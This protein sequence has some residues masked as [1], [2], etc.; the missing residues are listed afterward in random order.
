MHAS[1]FLPL[2]AALLPAAAFAR[3]PASVTT[4]SFTTSSVATIPC[5]TTSM[6]AACTPIE[7]TFVYPVVVTSSDYPL[8]SGYAA[9]SGYPYSGYGHDGKGNGGY[10]Y[11][12]GPSK[13]GPYYPMSNSTLPCG[14]GTAPAGTAVGTGVGTVG[15][16]GTFVTSTATAGGSE[17][18]GGES[19]DGTV[20]GT[21]AKHV[22][23]LGVVLAG[24]VVAMI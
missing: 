8:S 16:T 4:K 13:S 18:T 7:T 21:G 3:D 17:A 6:E 1:A 14:T 10:G 2:I 20:T 19:N 9:P 22:V 5:P 15:S 11:G 24:L 23:G 12:R